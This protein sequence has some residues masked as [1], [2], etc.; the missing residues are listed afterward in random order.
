MSDDKAF[1]INDARPTS[2]RHLIGQPSV[3]EQIMVALDS[4]QQDNRPF[5]SALLVGPRMWQDCRIADHR[6]RDG[7]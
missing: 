6:C 7:N 1:D 5:D 4:A 2:V 3:V